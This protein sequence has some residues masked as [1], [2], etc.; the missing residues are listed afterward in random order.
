MRLE[1]LNFGYSY[2]YHVHGSC[3]I[4]L[5]LVFIYSDCLINAIMQLA[6]QTDFHYAYNFLL[7]LS[8]GHHLVRRSA[9][10]PKPARPIGVLPRPSL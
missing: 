5:M 9:A 4:I 2:R 3:I 10:R 7:R 8:K 1:K 6:G